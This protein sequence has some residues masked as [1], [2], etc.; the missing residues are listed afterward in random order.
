MRLS[1]D[2][3][4]NL[5]FVLDK[6]TSTK[7]TVHTFSNDIS[8][9]CKTNWIKHGL[10]ADVRK[11]EQ[12]YIVELKQ[13][14]QRF[15]KCLLNKKSVFDDICMRYAI[16]STTHLGTLA[17]EYECTKGTRLLLQKL[18][19]LNL[20]VKHGQLRVCFFIL[21]TDNFSSDLPTTTISKCI[22]TTSKSWVDIFMTY[23]WVIWHTA[24]IS[25]CLSNPEWFIWAGN[26]SYNLTS[27]G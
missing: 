25:L 14:T 12:C 3:Y 24:K 1:L 15:D 26:M 19:T 5:Y 11:L 6:I 4:G 21:W 17:Q 23:V 9:C 22:E 7:N 13:S 27:I 16:M 20:G 18:F 2:I 8:F 10:I